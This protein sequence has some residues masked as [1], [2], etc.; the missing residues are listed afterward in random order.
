VKGEWREGMVG[1][2][3]VDEW[4]GRMGGKNGEWIRGRIEWEI[5]WRIKG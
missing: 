4:E 2:R 1:R 3:M 5:E